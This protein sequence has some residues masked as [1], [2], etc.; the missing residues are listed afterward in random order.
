MPIDRRFILGS[1]GKVTLLPPAYLDHATGQEVPEDTRKAL[2]HYLYPFYVCGVT[3]TAEDGHVMPCP[4]SH[5]ESWLAYAR[6]VYGYWAFNVGKADES[7]R[8][9]VVSR[10]FHAIHTYILRGFRAS[11]PAVPLVVPP[12]FAFDQRTLGAPLF[13][14]AGYTEA[15]LPPAKAGAFF[16][17]RKA[18][19]ALIRLLLQR[20]AEQC[21]PSFARF[22]LCVAKSLGTVL[23]DEVTPATSWMGPTGVVDGIS[24]LD[25]DEAIT[26][27]WPGGYSSG[28]GRPEVPDT[29]L[30]PVEPYNG[31]GW[32]HT[33]PLVRIFTYR[34]YLV[35]LPPMISSPDLLREP[36]RDGTFE[37]FALRLTTMTLAVT[38]G[39]ALLLRQL[40]QPD[41][42]DR[43]ITLDWPEVNGGQLQWKS[44]GPLAAMG[45]AIFD[46]NEARVVLH[47]TDVLEGLFSV[48]DVHDGMVP[49]GVEQV[50]RYSL[51]P[52]DGAPDYE[53]M[54]LAKV[55][56]FCFSSS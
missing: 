28:W 53:L 2:D 41:R 25:S 29:M 16:V 54:A 33:L 43:P 50:I 18:G 19:V 26:V 47:G 49:A 8:Y 38:P 46:P 45:V 36:S 30:C 24:A 12:P 22:A 48:I 42:G 4:R 21:D 7:L 9:T 55:N 5:V 39:A 51:P 40:A 44:T 34:G 1:Y 27:R 37:C 31:E 14:Q 17:N 3:V 56:D 35:I 52:L 32:R 13:S 10:W 15:E 20:G 23:G 11:V 6:Q